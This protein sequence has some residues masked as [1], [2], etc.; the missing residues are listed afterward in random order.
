MSRSG[1]DVRARPY[2]VPAPGRLPGMENDDHISEDEY[3]H[4]IE[5]LQAFGSAPLAVGIPNR[6]RAVRGRKARVS[7]GRAKWLI[8]GSLAGFMAGSVGLAAADVLPAPVQDVAHHAL[9]SVGVHVPPGHQRFNDPATCPGG[10]YANHGAYV[11]A[12]H[13]D[14]NAGS[15]PCGKPVQA[16]NPGQDSNS[17]E[18][19]GNHGKGSKPNGTNPGNGKGKGHDNGHGEGHGHGNGNGNGEGHGNGPG[20]KPHGESD[21]KSD[22]DSDQP[23]AAVTTSTS[24]PAPTTPSSTT[25][26]TTTTTAP[27]SPTT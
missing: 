21:D 4:V 6:A 27:T 9:D 3:R 20:L 11:R 18:Q 2:P 22:T 5:R 12:H 7:G 16:V 8:A 23:P 13:D 25:V 14:P 10:P 26:S 17:D 1:R 19:P 15:S 24:M